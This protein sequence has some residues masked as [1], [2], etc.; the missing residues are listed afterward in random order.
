MKTILHQL[1][2]VIL[3]ATVAQCLVAQEDDANLKKIVGTWTL[4]I[5]KT[6]E[7]IDDEEEVERMREMASRMKMQMIF[8]ADGSMDMV[9]GDRPMPGE[10]TF[11]L[12][13]TKDEENKY[14]VEI[15][16]TDQDE[17]MRGTIKFADDNTIHVT[18]EG[19]STVVMVREIEVVDP[20]KAK[21]FF[22]GRWNANPEETKK[23]IE[24]DDE[25]MMPADGEIPSVY[26]ILKEDGTAKL[27]EGEDMEFDAEYT[28]EAGDED[29]VFI[30]T[31]NANEMGPE[32]LEITA[33]VLGKNR[34]MFRPEGEI[35]IILDRDDK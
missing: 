5:D 24:A 11:K 31:F 19:Q 3:V 32:G 26:I 22:T 16:R 17:P 2:A 9:Q 20:E 1:M 35:P 33:T 28:I 29:N 34:V 4:D 13:A 21:E 30:F 6:A 10:P 7:S 18:P 8:R 14:D 23:M 25:L 15:T 27:G 12:T